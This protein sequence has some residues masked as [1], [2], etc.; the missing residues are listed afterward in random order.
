MAGSLLIVAAPSGAGKTSLVRHLLQARPKVRLSVSFTTRPP[1]PGEI[2]GR[3]Y[4][5]VDQ[6]RFE[7]LRDAGQLLEWAVVHGNLYGTSRA[8]IEA[9]M[10]EGNDIVLEID[11]QGAAQVMGDFSSAVGIYILP[12]SMA[13][14]RERLI[15]RGQDAAEVIE[16]RLA[17]AKTE[18]EQAYRFQYVIIN[19][20]FNAAAAE[21]IAI[22]DVARLRFDRQLAAEPALF[23]DLGI[24]AATTQPAHPLTS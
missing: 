10:D 12:P 18:L 13:A 23:R 16:R 19:Q 5:F 3:D 6:A 7:A 1:R 14:L 24:V 15:G 17:A 8:W 9:Q 4:F 22:A 11:W 20:D 2:D 21:L